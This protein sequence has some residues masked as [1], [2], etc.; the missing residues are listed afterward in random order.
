M[1][2]IFKLR[3][4]I[5]PIIIGIIIILASGT[6]YYKSSSETADGLTKSEEK[7]VRLEVKQ[8]IDEAQ[9]NDLKAEMELL[10]N[11]NVKLN[12]SV[13]ALRTLVWQKK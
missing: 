9:L 13:S 2:N 1:N 8:E 6:S 12:A 10:R 11:E 4:M 5:K 3:N 7:L